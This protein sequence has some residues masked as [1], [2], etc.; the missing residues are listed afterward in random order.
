MLTNYLDRWQPLHPLCYNEVVAE[1]LV[2]V[3]DEELVQ[4]IAD[5]PALLDLPT[6]IAAQK[7]GIKEAQLRRRLANS[8]FYSRVVAALLQRTI[9]PQE[10]ADLLRSLFE[11]AKDPDQPLPARVKAAEFVALQTNTLRPKPTKHEETRT[12]RVI[13][14]Y[15][16]EESKLFTQPKDEEVVDV[17]A[18]P[19]PDEE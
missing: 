10:H 16:P 17:E 9:R 6:H 19:R 2:K 7:L 3:D 4:R 5:D 13:F 14:G 11:S 18:L 12:F 15:R 1:S 8:E